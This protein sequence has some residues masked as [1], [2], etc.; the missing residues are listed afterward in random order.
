MQPYNGGDVFLY[1]GGADY[2]GGL[3]F[4]VLLVQ[5]WV[6]APDSYARIDMGGHRRKAVLGFR[7]QGS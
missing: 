5:T 2:I 6:Y 4:L 3:H 7:V 1:T